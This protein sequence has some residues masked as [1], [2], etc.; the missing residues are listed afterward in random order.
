MET[1]QWIRDHGIESAG[2]FYGT[3]I[4]VVKNNKD[5]LEANRIL[6][7]VPEVYGDTATVRIALPNFGIMGE[8]Y[9]T[10]FL[11]KVNA[12]VSITFRQGDPE[13]PFWSP[14]P[15]ADKERPKEFDRDSIFGFR[16]RTGHLVAV[17]DENN[18]ITIQHKDGYYLE[19]KEDKVTIG[20]NVRV[21]IHDKG[22]DIG[23]QANLEPAVLGNTLKD[24]LTDL[25]TE[26]TKLTTAQTIP[27]NAAS[28]AALQVHAAKLP[29][30]L[31]KFN[32]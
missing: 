10:H 6:T 28:I 26:I 31:A 32:S 8:N 1:K 21:E 3:Y 2:R 29:E 15:W 7:N 20:N 11:P 16:S 14:A 25:V 19:V 30:I 17:D 24:W 27:M 4:G 12:L 22:I 23:K 9:G 5:P 13:Y 18:S